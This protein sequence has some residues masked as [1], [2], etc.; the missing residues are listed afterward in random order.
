ME[1][2]AASL[3]VDHNADERMLSVFNLV[4]NQHYLHC[5]VDSVALD[6]LNVERDRNVVQPGYCCSA[7]L[8]LQICLHDKTAR[9]IN[10]HL[11]AFLVKGLTCLHAQKDIFYK[12]CKLTYPFTSF[13]W[14]RLVSPEYIT[15]VW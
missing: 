4:V 11:K 14:C 2:I 15:L 6:L 7:R 10:E 3:I 9:E 8:L 12:N 1:R 5:V 13:H